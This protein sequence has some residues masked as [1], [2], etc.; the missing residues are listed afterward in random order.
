MVYV[1]QER[2]YWG[3]VFS[4]VE[5]CLLFFRNAVPR[6]FHDLPL[7]YLMKKLQWCKKLRIALIGEK[8]LWYYGGTAG[9]E[10]YTLCLQFY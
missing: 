10:V 7:P 9:D 2:C 4:R 5:L 8:N 3:R 6:G 1:T